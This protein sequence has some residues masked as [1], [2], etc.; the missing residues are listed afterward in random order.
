ML[1]CALRTR[2]S[3]SE[4][5]LLQPNSTVVPFLFGDVQMLEL[6][7]EHRVDRITEKHW[8]AERIDAWSADGFN[9]E[10]FRNTLENEPTL[11]S[12]MLL[13]FETLISRNKALRQR[14]INSPISQERKSSWLE[15]L[16]DASKTNS[17]I[18]EWESSVSIERP[19]EPY[20]YR[21][22]EAWKNSGKDFA[23]SQLIQRL[24]AL[25]PSSIPATQ[26]LLVLLEDPVA[27]DSISNMIAV[28]ELEESRRKKVIEEIFNT[29]WF[30][31]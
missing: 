22:K 24:E 30:A 31:D 4:T 6:T 5:P 14:I 7:V 11:S 20:A 9:V 26:P 13:H 25:D 10:S 18:G 1:S 17:L 29:I 8:W 27:E 12:E 19:W 15:K 2:E 21:A 23:L 28:V 3:V 16:D